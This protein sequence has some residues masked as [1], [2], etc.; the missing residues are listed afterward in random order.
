LVVWFASVRWRPL[1]SGQ[2]RRPEVDHIPEAAVND[3][4]N[5]RE[6]IASCRHELLERTW[7]SLQSLEEQ[8]GQPYYLVLN[9]RA[10]NPKVMAEKMAL[11]NPSHLRKQPPYTIPAFRK[12]LQHALERFA[13]LLL[14]E[15]NWKRNLSIWD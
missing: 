9:Y 6:F 15:A 3:D 1:A 12:L 13:D 11:E 5:E 14:T 7:E 2:R 8:T 10:K 4:E